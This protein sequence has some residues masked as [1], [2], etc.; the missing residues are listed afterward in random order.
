MATNIHFGAS[1]TIFQYA[2]ILRKNMVI[3][4][5]KKEDIGTKKKQLSLT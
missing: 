1:K 3:E 2:E 5:I 4:E